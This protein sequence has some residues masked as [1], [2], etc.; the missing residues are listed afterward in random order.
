MGRRLDVGR[1]AV[2][3]VTA[4]S[5]ALSPAVPL[6]TASPQ[7]VTVTPAPK[8]GPA[9]PVTPAPQGTAAA[10][11][12]SPAP[13]APVDGGWPR[14]YTTPSGGKII[15][16]QPQVASWD[17]Q[18]QMVAYAAVSYEAKGAPKPAIGSLK[19]EANTKV[20]VS[21]RLVSFKDMR[22]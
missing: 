19:I 15:V 14:G 2:A 9:P 12:A 18:K 13:P 1:S 22:I 7:A 10:K 17:Q 8:A 4:F 3:L 6:V 20:A 11:P 16:Y 5:F 21:E